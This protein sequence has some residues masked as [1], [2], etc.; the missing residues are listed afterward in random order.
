MAGRTS[1]SSSP[2]A[3]D[4]SRARVWEAVPLLDGRFDVGDTVRVLGRVW[5]YEG[6]VELELR[7]VERLPTA[8]RSSS[9]PAPVATPSSSTATS[10]SC[11]PRSMTPSCAPWPRRCS[12][13]RLP[14]ALP[15]RRRDRVGHHAYAGG[16]IEHTVAV[17][18]LCREAAQLHP[19]LDTDVL[20]AAALLHDCGCLDAL[21]EGP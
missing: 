10:S 4:A 18:T 16:L 19:G 12:R 2:T 7:D 15:R 14:C 5:S 1:T 13:S 3:A 6:K 17:A 9:C 8:T 21:A 11:S 20:T